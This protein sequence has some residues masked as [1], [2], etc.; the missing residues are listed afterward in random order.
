M[1][2]IRA[3]TDFAFKMRSK[4][5]IYPRFQLTLVAATAL[6]F[7]VASALIGF[8][9]W[10]SVKS[11]VDMGVQA[12]LQPDHPYFQFLQ[13]QARTIYAFVAAGCG[14]GLIISTATVFYVSHRMAGPLVRLQR[15]FEEIRKTGE[16]RTIAFRKSDYFSELP[17]VINEGLEAVR[18]RA[19]NQ[20]G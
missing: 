18:V 4:Y 11:L 19:R 9:T 6:A 8:Q 17:Q 12:G 14:V 10:R 3:N 5:L 16:V 7:A 2:Q 20:A 13:L 1:S 15:H